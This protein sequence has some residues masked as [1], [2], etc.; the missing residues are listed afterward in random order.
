M[1]K[2]GSR[3]PIE[4]EFA[5]SDVCQSVFRSLFQGIK[6]NRYR[7]DRPTDLERL[8]QVMV[9]FNVAAKARRSSV[10][11]RKLFDEFDGEAWVD[12]NRPPDEVVGERELADVIRSQFTDD[13]LEILTLW[14]DDR[15]W[16][17]IA[18]VLGGTADSLRVRLRRAIA[19]IRQK[20]NGAT[21]EA[22]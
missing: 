5:S 4:R 3:G 6:D 21:T 14:L 11:L 17:Q 7:F 8:L 9:R 22:G 16:V 18:A 15:T 19:R 12:G 13:E 20:M 2:P 10:K 1:G